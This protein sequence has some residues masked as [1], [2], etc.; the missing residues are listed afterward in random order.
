M[1]VALPDR[2]LM[3]AEEYLAWELTQQERHEFWDGEVV[4]MAG[5]T[6][7]HN[8]VSG[9]CFKV[10]DGLMADR[11]CEVYITDVKVQVEANR[12]Y[13][14]PDVMVTCDGRDRDAQMVQYPC[15]IVEVLSSST[16]AVDRGA[17]F[18]YYRRFSTLREY[19]LIQQERPMVEVFCRNE[20][21]KWV[22]TEYGLGDVIDLESLG[23]QVSVLDLYDRVVFDAIDDED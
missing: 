18:T 21:G 8:R 23:C 19:V 1:M 6:K 14:Y 4:L 3:S 9:N 12:K 7:R 11:D 13:F 16:E 15:L 22:L 5:G 17:K 20:I 2:I 10:L